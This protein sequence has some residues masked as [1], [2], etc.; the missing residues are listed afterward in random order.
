MPPNA[1]FC[2]NLLSCVVCTD[3]NPRPAPIIH[4]RP[5]NQ[6]QP[7]NSIALLQSL[8]KTDKP[9]EM[10]SGMWTLWR[11]REPCIRSGLDPPGEDVMFFGGGIFVVN[12]QSVVDIFKVIH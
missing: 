11:P 4:Q 5:Q 6:T 2:S 12:M 7:I 3:E 8:V 10:L 1:A 9:I